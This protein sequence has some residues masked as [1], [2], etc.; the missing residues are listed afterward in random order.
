MT[1]LTCNTITIDEFIKIENENMFLLWIINSFLI[2]AISF[3]LNK[4]CLN[5]SY[6]IL[7]RLQKLIYLHLFTDYFMNISAQSLEQ[8][9]LCIC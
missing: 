8:I 1:T 7:Q 3:L 4:I 6:I 9:Q 2:N 5:Q